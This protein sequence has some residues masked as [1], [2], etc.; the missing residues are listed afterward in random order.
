[1]GTPFTGL[2]SPRLAQI[3]V[4]SAR[5]AILGA[6]IGAET[7]KSLERLGQES[8]TAFLRTFEML[9]GPSAGLGLAAGS[10][11]RKAPISSAIVARSGYVLIRGSPTRF[12]SEF[13][14]DP[15]F[16]LG[17]QRAVIARLAQDI[18]NSDAHGDVSRTAVA[19]ERLAGLLAHDPALDKAANKELAF[20]GYRLQHTG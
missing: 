6:T 3:P 18:C 15:P 9:S 20:Y 7:A 11:L 16:R 8:V 10:R 1:M 17:P 19:F 4:D 12:R 2:L 13:S 5:A 14:Y